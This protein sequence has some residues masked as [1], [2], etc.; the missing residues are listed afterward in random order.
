MRGSH[1]VAFV[2]LRKRHHD[3]PQLLAANN[4]SRVVVTMVLPYRGWLSSG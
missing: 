1:S 4:L 3:L 2:E